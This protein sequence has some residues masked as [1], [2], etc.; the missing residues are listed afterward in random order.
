L[1]DAGRYLGHPLPEDLG[2]EL[3]TVARRG[4]P[5]KFVFASGDPGV[6]L[7]RSQGG[8]S[9]QRL[10]EL[11]KLEQHFIAGADHTFTGLWMQEQL[12]AKLSS[13]VGEL[14]T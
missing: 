6:E 13:L 7:L 10:S 1:R 5:M 9:V 4:V 3:E 8:R 2:V 14:P 11:G 12:T